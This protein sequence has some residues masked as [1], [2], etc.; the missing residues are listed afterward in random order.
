MSAAEFVCIPERDG[1]NSDGAVIINFGQKMREIN[2]DVWTN[3]LVNKLPRYN[4]NCVVDDVR[5]INEYKKLKELGF[6]FIR[7][8]IELDFQIERINM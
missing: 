5:F 4:I 2:P 1:T 8:E 6:K 3:Y 7:L